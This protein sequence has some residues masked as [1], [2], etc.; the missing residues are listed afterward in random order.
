MTR[1]LDSCETEQENM[2]T[3]I[4]Q[5]YTLED[6]RRDWANGPPVSA[7]TDLSEIELPEDIWDLLLD[8]A[9]DM[10]EQDQR[11]PVLAEQSAAEEQENNQ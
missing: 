3:K 1:L 9:L 2:T 8:L 7:E 10:C 11:E 5:P 6:S 4:K